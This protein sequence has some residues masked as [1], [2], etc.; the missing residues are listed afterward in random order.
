MQRKRPN[1]KH[2]ARRSSVFNS[3]FETLEA[4]QLMSFTAAI[5]TG[6]VLQAQY[7]PPPT[8]YVDGTAGNDFIDVSY[9]ESPYTG[10]RLTVL[11]AGFAQIPGAIRRYPGG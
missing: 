3:S 6:T 5:S 9:S 7:V 4:R 2:L 1:R 11:D 8:Y 10:R